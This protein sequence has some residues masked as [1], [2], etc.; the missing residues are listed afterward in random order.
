MTD[1]V[2]VY[3]PYEIVSLRISRSADDEVTASPSSSTWEGYRCDKFVLDGRDCILVRPHVALQSKPWIWRT[4]F[5]GEFHTLDLALLKAGFHVAYI[6][7]RNMYGAPTALRIMDEYY[8]H[9]T[10]PSALAPVRA[11]GIQPGRAVCAQLGGAQSAIGGV[12][13]S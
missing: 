1:E 10:G 2:V 12:P 13:V 5:F 11:G 3:R 8:A 7:M 4:E 9:L 6:D